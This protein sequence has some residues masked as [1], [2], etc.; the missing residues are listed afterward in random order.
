MISKLPDDERE[1][2]ALKYDQGLTTVEIGAV[3]GLSRFAVARKLKSALADL[4]HQMTL[5]ER[6]QR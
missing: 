2:V 6:G 3:T 1:I 5:A 4:R